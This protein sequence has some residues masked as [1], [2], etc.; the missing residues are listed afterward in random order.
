MRY[1][2]AGHTGLCSFINQRRISGEKSGIASKFFEP[3][4]KKFSHRRVVIPPDVKNPG[5]QSFGIV[6]QPENKMRISIEYLKY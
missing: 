5:A 3:W 6:G 2:V 4:Q 1:G